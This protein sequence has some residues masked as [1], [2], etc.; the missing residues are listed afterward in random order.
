MKLIARVVV[1]GAFQA[2]VLGSMVAQQPHMP[3][4]QAQR[5]AM[6]KLEFL[7]GRWS[8]PVTVVRGPG[9][10]L[11]LTQT[12]NVAYKLDGLVMQIE[13]QSTG[14]DGKA[15]F[16]ALG[17]I[18][19]DDSSQTYRFRAY[20]EGRY[21]DTELTVLADGFAWGFDAGP[22]KVQNT[23]HLTVKGEWQEITEVAFGSAPA[24]RS[25]EML[26]DRQR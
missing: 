1:A 22:A 16:R 5:E 19:Y 26:L 24:R 9:E 20:N 25:V 3:N 2:V 7:A 12:E 8:G 13:G 17:T 14:A 11:K 21:L 6:Q 10:P 15:Q 18:A 23:M 4:V